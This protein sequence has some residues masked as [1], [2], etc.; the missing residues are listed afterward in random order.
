MED[1]PALEYFYGVPLREPY[2]SE[3]DFFRANPSVAGM[4]AE[5]DRIIINPRLANDPQNYRAVAQNEAVRVLLRRNELPA[6]KFELTSEILQ[7]LGN[8]SRDPQDIRETVA[9]RWISGDPSA[10]PPSTKEQASY[11]DALRFLLSRRE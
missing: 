1:R 2:P 11:L 6:P 8:Y 5:D 7:R 4:A 10:P 3:L 9:A